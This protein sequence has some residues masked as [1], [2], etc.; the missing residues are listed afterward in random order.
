[1]RTH[2]LPSGRLKNDFGEVNEPTFRG[3]ERPCEIIFCILG[4]K[5]SELN[6][7][8]NLM[9]QVGEWP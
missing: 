7:D 5:K 2:N 3:V 6:D 4:I 9:F 8:E 1:M